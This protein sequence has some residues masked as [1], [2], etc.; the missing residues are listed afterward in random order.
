MKPVTLTAAALLAL[1]PCAFAQAPAEDANAAEVEFKFTPTYLH[2]SDGNHATDLNLRF[3]RGPHIGWV[4]HYR[5]RSGYRQGRLGYEY[6]VELDWARVALSAQYAQGGY[7][8]AS[9]GAELGGDTF[10]I[11]GIDR[12]NLR[13]YYNLNFDPGNAVVLGAGTRV[14]PKTDL[15]LFQVRDAR[16]N[17]HQQV[18]HAVLRWRPAKGRRL[19]LDLFHKSG[20]GDSGRVRGTGIGIGYDQDN[21]FVKVVRDPYVNFTSTRQ[22]RISVGVRF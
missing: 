15:S 13:D 22:M 5:D 12:N 6:R 21:L 7:V 19:T 8:G 1:A 10:A 14:V 17:T 9:V 16:L 18:T 11:V 3:G 4:G 2:S 20:E